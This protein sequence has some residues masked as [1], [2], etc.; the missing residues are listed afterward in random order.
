MPTLQPTTEARQSV[1]AETQPRPRIVVPRFE[2]EQDC[3]YNT[4]DPPRMSRQKSP[5][6]V[7][8]VVWSLKRLLFG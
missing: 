7:P 6:Y 2:T 4:P 3:L 8:S 5:M 1:Q